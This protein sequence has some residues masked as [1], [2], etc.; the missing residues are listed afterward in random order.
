MADAARLKDRL[1]FLDVA[2]GLA[3]LLVFVSHG[4]GAYFPGFTR[5]SLAYFNIGL[6]GVLIFLVVSGFII[7]VSLEQGGS[8]ARFWLR[9]FFRLFPLYWLS[10]ALAYACHRGGLY[11]AAFDGSSDWLL[12]LTM[13]QGFFDR[14]H[15]WGV[16]WTLQLEL[17][18]YASCS[19]LFAVGLL[20]RAV[21]VAG[22][23]FVAYAVLGIARPVLTGS[24]FAIGGPRFLYFAPVVG[25][26]AQRYWAGRIGRRGFLTLVLAHVGGVAAVWLVNHTLLPERMT[27]ACLRECATMWG[28]A[29]A[30]F[31]LLLALRNRRLPDV[32]CWLG[33]ISYSVYLLHG[34]VIMLLLMMG[35]SWWVTLPVA[36]AATLLLSHLTYR[37]VEVPGIALGRA[38]ERRWFPSAAR[39]EAVATPAP[40]RRAA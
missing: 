4:L 17:V 26:V 37:F 9:R 6:I 14:P 21:G 32:A 28:T 20:K 5:W 40:A 13:L 29:Y 35:W 25:L 33:R 22:V 36:L 27:S 3:A 18:I 1:G 31:F 39:R 12:N 7:P 8:N 10:I 16:F 34:M 23:A 19:L 24:P 30:C 11:G 38:I 2:R 15:A